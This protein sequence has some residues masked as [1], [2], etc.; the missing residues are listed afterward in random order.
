MRDVS[1]EGPGGDV[2]ADIVVYSAP[3]DTIAMDG[4]VLRRKIWFLLNFE[5]HEGHLKSSM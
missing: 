4:V 1:E 5:L 3:E 2:T